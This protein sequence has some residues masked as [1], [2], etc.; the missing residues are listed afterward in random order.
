MEEFGVIIQKLVK[1]DRGEVLTGLELMMTTESAR[2]SIKND[3]ERFGDFL[4]HQTAYNDDMT[5]KDL[6]EARQCP[7]ATAYF[8]AAE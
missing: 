2:D 3:V 6:K 7:G 5:R 1:E 4:C 8:K